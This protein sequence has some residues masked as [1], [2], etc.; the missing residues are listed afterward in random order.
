MGKYIQKFSVLFILILL[1]I[2]SFS[3]NQRLVHRYYVQSTYQ[4]DTALVNVAKNDQKVK[5]LIDS[6]EKYRKRIFPKLLLS[7]AI[8]G[9]SISQLPKEYAYNNDVPL[10]DY[11][12][13]ERRSALTLLMSGIVFFSTIK[14]I[15]L[16]DYYISRAYDSAHLS[17]PYIPY[18]PKVALKRIDKTKFKKFYLKSRVIKIGRSRSEFDK[19]VQLIYNNGNNLNYMF[20]KNPPIL[21][22]VYNK[23]YNYVMLDSNKN[24]INIRCC[25]EFPIDYYFVNNQLS[26]YKINDSIL[27]LSFLKFNKFIDSLQIQ[28]QKRKKIIKQKR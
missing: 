15:L 22:D 25:N 21:A 19:R 5:L 20:I 27:N 10:Q 8:Y 28:Q 23:N 9:L 16:K 1:N 4:K 17:N 26:E 7:A 2:S 18:L 3:Q 6:A 13:M 24:N 12:S 11:K 14:P